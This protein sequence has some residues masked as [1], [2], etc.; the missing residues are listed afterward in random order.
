MK[1][2]IVGSR[3]FQD[4]ETMCR[5]ISEKFDL[6]DIEAVVS[7]GAKGADTLAERFAKDNNLKMIVKPAEWSKYGRAAGPMRNKLIVE[8]ADAVVAFPT[9]TSTG[10]Y[11]AIKLTKKAG[12]RLEVLDVQSNKK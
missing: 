7:G 10:T 11:N 8:E 1:L 3:N 4:Y 2:A 5:F 12:K 9:E 6:S